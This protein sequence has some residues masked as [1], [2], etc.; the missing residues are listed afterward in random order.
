MFISMA[1]RGSSLSA[2]LIFPTGA[3]G[4][5]FTVIAGAA[6]GG[7]GFMTIVSV[8]GIVCGGVGLTI[9][10]GTSTPARG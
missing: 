7:F 4:C 2:G 3:G 1:S 6:A 10:V 9:G 5:L 8:V